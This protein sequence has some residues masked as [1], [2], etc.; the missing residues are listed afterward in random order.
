MVSFDPDLTA[1]PT[2]MGTEAVMAGDTRYLQYWYR[3]SLIGIAT[4]N[5]SG[6]R[7]LTFD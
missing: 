5:F 3:D 4:S 2:S 1:F 6:A 7:S